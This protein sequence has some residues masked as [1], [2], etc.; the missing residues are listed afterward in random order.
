MKSTFP[1][2][3]DD[4]LPALR[5]AL[6]AHPNAVLVAPPGAG[7]T[8]RVPLD[9]LG[10]PWRE[11]GRIILLEPR[12]IAARAAAARMAATLNEKVGETVGLRVR[13]ESRTST[14]T[15]I[16]VVTEGVFTRMILED[17]ELNGVAAVLLDEFH[18][19]S[20]DADLALALALDAQGAFRSDLRILIMSATLDGA[21]VADLLGG[22]V[23]ESAGRSFPVETRYVPRDPARRLEDEVAA[24]VIRALAEEQGSI[25][26]FLPGQAEIRRTRE[27]LEGRIA[28]GSELVEL[29]GGLEPGEQDRAIRPAAEGRRKV[30]LATAIAETSLTI[31][32]VRVVVDAGQARVPV[33]EPATGLT[34]LATVKVSRASADQRR[35]RAGRVAPGV[36]YRLWEEAATSGLEPYARPEILS[37]GLDG[38]ALDLAVWGV[39]QPDALAWLDPPPRAAWAEAQDTLRAIG[40]LDDAGR[41]TPRGQAIHA[42]PLPPRLAAMVVDAAA[43]GA[44]RRAAEIAVLLVERGLGGTDVDLGH[45]L[46][47]LRRDR[48][49]RARAARSMAAHWAARAG[50][51]AQ[52]DETVGIGALVARAYPDRIA[53]ARGPRGGFRLANGRGATLD[54]SDALASESYLVIADLTGAAA[55]ARILAAAAISRDEIEELCAGQ[56]SESDETVFDPRSAALRARTIRRLGALVLADQPRPVQADEEAARILARGIASMGL[57]CLP[58]SKALKQWRDRVMFMHRNE[59]DPWPDLSDAA[60]A[61]S[62]EE[63]LAPYLNGR[64]AL[65]GISTEDLS[66]ALRARL[67]YDLA[68]RL[69]AE[70]PASFR[71][72][73]GSQVAIS[74]ENGEPV[75]AIRV[76]ELF[77]LNTHPM[78]AD[79]RVP[80]LLE[81]LSPASRPVQVTRDLPGFWAGSWASVRADMRGRYPRHPWPED[82]ASAVPT[83]RAKPRST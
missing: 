61:A 67:S 46:D 30:V 26:V 12:R 42:L 16:E 22:P 66:A 79:G 51:G 43:H 4:A 58:W 71:A 68:R 70:A 28:A 36:C 44:A 5:A 80:L 24:C 81:L 74:Y 52:D 6:I 55:S 10:A 64:T 29:H 63:W 18:E 41:P 48:S 76:Q 65:S 34:R 53:Q 14:R 23:I 45:R 32:G 57:A 82:P 47:A 78:L 3:V 7:K 60:L 49:P 59:G 21:R 69:D 75:L 11:G 38:L 54:L 1:L 35:G 77:G 27:R 25:L 39:R 50:D 37:A 72:P 31:E 20:L 17:P 33:Y 15:K 83:N 2:P 40:A 56:I 73:T 62:V 19:R 9:L 13:M 8:T